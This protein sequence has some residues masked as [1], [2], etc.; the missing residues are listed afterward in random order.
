MHHGRFHPR[1]V[2]TLGALAMA[3]LLLS[4]TAAF[5]APVRLDCSLRDVETRASSKFDRL[6]GAENRSITVVFDEQKK[7]LSV[8]Q[9]GNVR[10]LDDVTITQITVSGT[11]DEISLGIDRSSLNIVFQTYGPDL[12]RA[13]FGTCSVS[14]EP[15]L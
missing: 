12:M 8:Y 6:V 1:V 7:A 10:V 9:D 4:P 5:G 11:V 2:D 13:E 14:A 15:V 3:L